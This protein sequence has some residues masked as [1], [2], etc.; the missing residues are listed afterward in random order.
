VT[1]VKKCKA[2]AYINKVEGLNREKRRI[3]KQ[4][5]IPEW[6]QHQFKFFFPGATGNDVH[7]Q[8]QMGQ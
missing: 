6:Q 8:G 7:K 2:D 5:Y 4:W 3:C 1:T